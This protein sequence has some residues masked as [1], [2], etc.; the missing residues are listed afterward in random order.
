MINK[1]VKNRV[2]FKNHSNRGPIKKS[3]AAS[4]PPTPV[5]N[6]GLSRK[7]SGA[8]FHG[9]FPRESSSAAG[10]P[11]K[12]KPFPNNDINCKYY[13]LKQNHNTNNISTE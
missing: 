7:S 10:T 6:N 2:S 13:H 8:S 5:K 4:E 1:Q 3:K 12:E 9:E 11:L